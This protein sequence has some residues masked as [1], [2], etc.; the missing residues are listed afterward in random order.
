MKAFQTTQVEL[1]Q[2]LRNPDEHPGLAG[3]ED[4]RL[5]IYRE[6]IF[7]NIEG[8]ISGSFPVLHSLFSSEQWVRLV[9][10]FIASHYAQTPYFLEISQEFLH[11][12]MHERAAATDD[13]PFM[14]ELAHYEW[15]ELAVD[16]ADV[17]LPSKG[18]IPTELL[19]SRP[20]V[21][22]ALMNLAYSYP[23]H[24][25]STDFIP[26]EPTPTYLVVYRNRADDVAFMESNALTNRLLYLLQTDTSNTLD[27][28]LAS[29]AQELAHPHPAQL[30]QQAL[31]LV[32]DLYQLGVISHFE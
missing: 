8:F 2:H 21:S 11:Y 31:A 27:V 25:I 13:F 17:E 14:I 29:I 16:V 15:V 9:R 23:V 3:V 19:S 18:V 20:R 22:P 7:G 32:V 24:Q 30:N 26:A 12:L 10:G 4:R 6:L 28:Q 1:T 5:G